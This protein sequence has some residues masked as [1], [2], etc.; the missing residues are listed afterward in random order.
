MVITPDFVFIHLTK[1]GGTYVTQMLSRLYGDRAVD[2]NQHGTCSDI[3]EQYRG[4]PLV[5]TVRSP[6]DRYVSQ[7]RYEWWKISPEE[8]C[9]EAAMR[10]M[11]P[12]YPD[13][14]FEEFLGL[15]NSKFMNCFRRVPTGF[16]NDNFPPER[17]LGWH[18]EGFV[19]FFF[20]HPREVYAR[21]DEETIESGG[22]AR[23]MFDVHFLRTANLRQGLHDY[24]LSLGHRPADLAF[25]LASE[26]V[27]P[28]DGH[29][30]PKNDP[31]QSYYTPELRELVRTR[32]RLI[33]RHFPDLDT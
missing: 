32:E 20:H 23:D 25:I 2:F 12:H 18:T 19:R 33:F 1:T 21:L 5:S 14:T 22:F 28:D 30:R 27:L 17:R 13:I 6:Y 29:R 11:F 8:Y 31:W 9:G 26:R 24:L 3:P 16:V 4:K 7:Y 10:E 15:A